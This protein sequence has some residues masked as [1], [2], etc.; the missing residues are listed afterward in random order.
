MDDMEFLVDICKCLQA[1][2]FFQ[3][4]KLDFLKQLI[5]QDLTKN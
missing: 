4:P 5:F 2:N 1:R 3:K